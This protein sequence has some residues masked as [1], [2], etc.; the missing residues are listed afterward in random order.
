MCEARWSVTAREGRIVTEWSRRGFRGALDLMLASRA[1]G[2]E[3]GTGVDFRWCHRVEQKAPG[4][5]L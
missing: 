5:E 3:M 4:S 1:L 2:I